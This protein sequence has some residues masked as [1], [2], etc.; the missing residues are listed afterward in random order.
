MVLPESLKWIGASAFEGCFRLP[1]VTIPAGVEEI[2]IEAF[3]GVKSVVS[4]SPRW[5][6]Q[7]PG[8]LV[9]TKKK[10]LHSANKNISG[11]LK[12]RGGI[13]SIADAA[14]E[15]CTMLT[16][17]ILPQ[18]VEKIGAG[19]F[20]GCRKLVSVKIPYT[21]REVGVGAFAGC[22]SLRSAVLSNVAEI[23]QMLFAGCSELTRVKLSSTAVAVEDEAFASCRSLEKVTLPESILSLGCDLFRGCCSLEQINFGK[24]IHTCESYLEKYK[25]GMKKR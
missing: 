18:W 3:S 21:V 20:S 10:V 11:T 19:A 5:V 23:R 7:E 15:D 12:V 25:W 22:S 17:V 9:D 4:K 2:G 13:T 14:F 8:L 24:E 1:A 6:V 16:E